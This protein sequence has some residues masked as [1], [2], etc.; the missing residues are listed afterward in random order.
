MS[1]FAPAKFMH[2]DALQY[3]SLLN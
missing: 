2:F 3:F 1:I